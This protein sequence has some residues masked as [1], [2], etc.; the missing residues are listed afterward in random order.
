MFDAA[1][2]IGAGACFLLRA[3]WLP[4]QPRAR[5]AAAHASHGAKL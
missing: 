3:V 4:A 2:R 5:V 1:R